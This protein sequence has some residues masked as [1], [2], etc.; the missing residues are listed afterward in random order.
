VTVVVD[1]AVMLAVM[2]SDAVLVVV[3]LVVEGRHS[4][5]RLH[6]AHR[7]SV[8]QG[9]GCCWQDERHNEEPSAPV[10]VVICVLRTGVVVIIVGDVNVV[11][12]VSMVV[13]NVGDVVL[14][15]G[16]VVVIIGMTTGGDCVGSTTLLQS[17]QVAQVGQL[18]LMY[19]GWPFPTQ[20]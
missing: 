10:V 20:Y 11:V 18:H 8:V 5:H 6:V 19:Q 16:I 14:G 7:Q 4:E 13:G 9:S 2:E 1:A 17:E 12:V 3:L 15:T